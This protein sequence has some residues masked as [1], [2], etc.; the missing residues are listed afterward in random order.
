MGIGAAAF[1]FLFF[2]THDGSPSTVFM[3][4]ETSNL[5]L[6]YIFFVFFFP[7]DHHLSSNGGFLRTNNKSD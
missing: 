2:L 3:A 1:G 7:V 6:F 4:W 5:T